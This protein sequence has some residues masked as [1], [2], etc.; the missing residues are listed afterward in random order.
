MQKRS[1]VWEPALSRIESANITAYMA[2]LEA[3]GCPKLDDYD[4]LYA[5]SVSE[6]EKFWSSIWDFCG[7]IAAKKYT[8]IL[9][10]PSM[11]G[12]KWFVGA[13]FNFAQ[14]LL[15]FSDETPAIIFWGESR[16]KKRLSYLELSQLVS[17]VSA[18]LASLGVKRGD[19]VAAFMPNIPETV[20]AMLATVALGAIWSSCSPDFGVAGI[21]DRFGQIE[22]KIIITSD[23]YFFKGAAI[24]SLKKIQEVSR[25]IISLEHTVVVPYINTRPDASGLMNPILWS[26]IIESSVPSEIKYTLTP[27]DHPLYIMYS[28]GTTGKPKCIVH[29]AGG[30]LIEH[31]KELILHTDLKRTDKIFYQ[32]TC[33]W[34]MWNWLVSSLAV[35][36]TVVLYDGAPFENEGRILFDLAQQEKITVFGTNA[37]Y[38]SATE[39]A[40]LVPRKTHDLSKLHTIL[41]TGSPLAPLSFDYVYRDIKSDLLLSSISGGTDILGC[42]ALG[43]PIKPVYRGE[44]QVRSLGLKVEVFN[45]CGKSVV[46]Q[47]GEL[48]CTKPFPSMPISFWNDKDNTRYKSAYFEKF[49][50]VWHHGDYVELTSRGGLVFYG[51]SD[52]A[53]NPGGVRIGT[54]EIYRQV[55]EFT[56]IEESVCVSQDWKDDVRIV[57]FL[58][59]QAGKTLTT[60]LKTEIQKKIR[61]NTS[62]FHVP[63]KIIQ[64]ADIPRTRSGKIVELAVRDLIHGH[65]PKNIQ[66]LANPEALD[67]FKNLPELNEE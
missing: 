34:M 51:R 55:E 46:D 31:L 11:P 15:K 22:P 33:G 58:K 62:P 38:L 17:K 52:T 47:K 27:F 37:K 21:V 24:D 9:D 41:S 40:G 32:T 42:F 6:N 39:K 36:A 7:V 4:S 13:E 48:V 2:W 3:N 53:L 5:W 64:V 19:R 45:N 23:G 12:A 30:T 59:L 56:E 65:T 61:A 26:E 20:V 50:G 43:C 60:E 44:L 63:K 57:L 49:P 8:R 16:V 18:K 1:K 67:Y 29:G 25:Q 28:S 54:A 10:N 66:A 35:G 14:N